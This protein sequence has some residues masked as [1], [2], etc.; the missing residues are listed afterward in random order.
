MGIFSQTVLQ[1]AAQT[2]PLIEDTP[3]LVTPAIV[4][5]TFNNGDITSNLLDN[6]LNSFALKVDQYYEYGRDTFVDGL[7][8]GSMG[9]VS[10]NL[11][12]V[13]KVLEELFPVPEGNRIRQDSSII[14][15]YSPQAFVRETL[16]KT[17]NWNPDTNIVGY[18]F[19]N[20]KNNWEVMM[21]SSAYVSS[22]QVSVTL[23]REIHMGG[24]QKPEYDY[25]FGYLN[26]CK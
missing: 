13:Q 16:R 18:P 26:Q 25:E 7:P 14:D 1:Q 24:D 8:E 17:S 10:P 4:D 9:H 19:D 22:T 15:T 20:P 23:R 2:L 6:I 12:D 11:Q 5:A 21:L 3:E